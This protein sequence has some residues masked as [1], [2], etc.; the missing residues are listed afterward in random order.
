MCGIAGIFDLEGS[1]EI[2]PGRLARMSRHV[3]HRGPDGEGVAFRP[4]LGLAHRRLA[5]IDLVTGQQ[6]MSDE[7]GSLLTVFNGEIYNF[8]ELRQRLVREGHRFRT[9]SDT[10][11]IV[12]GYRAWGEACPTR[13]RGMFAFA[14]W[15]ARE[16]SLF[17]ARDRL[18]EKPLYYTIS[19]GFLLFAS[20]LRA[21]IA[22]L[23]SVPD[24]DP[25]AVADYFALGYVPDPKS[26]FHGIA[27]L[28]PGHSLLF[29]RAARALPEPR[30]YW[31][32]QM[33]ER[34]GTE[35]AALAEEL[36]ERL[37]D[38]VRVR[39]ISDVP[40]GAFLS[41][42]VDSSAIVALLARSSG[43]PVR[44]CSIG[45][46]DPAMD[47]SAH[48]LELAQHWRTDHYMKRVSVDACAILDR[49]AA[50]YT[51]PFADSSAL[52]TY[53]V[54]QIARQR[55]TVALSGD[56]GDELFL[57]YR[58]YP[59][60]LREE[61]F[62]SWLPPTL[63]SAV[64]GPLAR[65]YPQLDRAP[66]PL[67]AKATLEALA[68]DRAHGYLRS[69]TPLPE[70]ERGRLFSLEFQHT[71]TGYDPA[72]RFA[73]LFE[74]AG[75]PDPLAQAQYADLATW[76]P[77]RML[78]KVDR[79]S[80]A[81]GLEVR[82]PLLDHEFVEWSLALPRHL[83]LQGFEGKALFKRALRSLVPAKLLDRPKQGF[84]IPLAGWLRGPLAERLRLI[85]REGRIAASGLFDAR[86]VETLVDQHVAGTR[87]HG[88]AL[89]SLL[90]FD[91]FLERRWLE[92]PMAAERAPA[93]VA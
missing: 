31:R 51:E 30:R 84:A 12:N 92:L 93:L 61:R 29:R 74:E 8:A 47:E 52:P 42:G 40:L 43:S 25:E 11:V 59:F 17:L 20:E 28:A 32:P 23:P 15:D 27:K 35:P 89:W 45:F 60:F 88:Q 2:E 71:L 56:G 54:S 24:L 80:M 33:G 34:T 70:P 38:A 90:M 79:A 26:I 83:H 49:I 16:Q 77:G 1:R 7:E 81:H 18:G 44:T 22:A 37:D 69:V 9:K 63:R 5:I 4:G 82:P 21:V 46:D 64:I 66:R 65:A 58:R 91:A 75:S 6:P 57:G 55:V 86:Q 68:A 50:A 78:V 41:G 67:R 73:E 53:I 87:D 72:S 48:A 19:D 85:S 3:A 39:T 36:V 10:E 13:L 62:K 76:L 14:I